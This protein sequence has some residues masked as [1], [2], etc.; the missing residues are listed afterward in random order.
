[1]SNAP[2][3]TTVHVILVKKNPP[4]G[5]VLWVDTPIRNFTRNGQFSKVAARFHAVTNH[6]RAP[7]TP[8]PHPYLSLLVFRD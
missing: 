7:V 4:M 2:K 8:H 3:N 6:E 1:M 5:T